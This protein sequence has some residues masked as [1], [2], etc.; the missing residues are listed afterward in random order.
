MLARLVDK[1][2][3]RNRWDEIKRRV[4]QSSFFIYVVGF[5]L[6]KSL[7]LENLSPFAIAFFAVMLT[8]RPQIANILA[9]VVSIGALTVHWQHAIY[10]GGSMVLLMIMYG[11]LEKKNKQDITIIPYQVLGAALISK[12]AIVY[13]ISELSNYTMIMAILESMLALLLTVIYIQ[14]VPIVLG[15]M[16][17]RVLKNEEIIC[18]LI[19]I[20]SIL[21][22]TTNWIWNDVHIDQILGGLAIIVMAY[23]GGTG[24]GAAI[25][26]IIGLIMSL[27]NPLLISQIATLAFAGLLAGL[28]REGKKLFVMV[29]YF[30][31]YITLSIY[32]RPGM[33]LLPVFVEIFT[34]LFLFSIVPKSTINY[35]AGLIPGTSINAWNQIEYKNKVKELVS[36]KVNRYGD[37]LEEL[38]TTFATKKINNNQEAEFQKLIQHV[39]DAS[40]K[41]CNRYNRCWQ[42]D[43]Y[44]SY[45]AFADIFIRFESGESVTPHNLP[46]ELRTQCIDKKRLI[47]ILQQEFTLF[48]KEYYW[49]EQVAECRGLLS[50]QFNGISQVMNQLAVEI[51][52]E[53]L[54]FSKQEVEISRAMEKLGLAIMHTQI[55]NL[56]KGNVE[57]RVTK[58]GCRQRGECTKVLAPMIADIVGENVSVQGKQGCSC[59][60]GECTVLITSAPVYDVE[61]GFVSIGKGGTFVS[62]DSYDGVDL[63]NGKYVLAISDGMG[64]GQRAREESQAAIKL[65]KT[66]LQAG[67]S[68]DTAIKTINAAL[69]LRSN[70]EIFATLDLAFINLFNGDTKFMKV[71]SSPSF[72]KSGNDVDVI[73]GESLPVGILQEIQYSLE[74]KTLKEGNIIVMMSDGILDSIR[75]IN[76][77]EDWLRRVLSQINCDKPQEI[78]DIIVEKVL[79]FNENEVIDDT[80][81]LVAKVNAYEPEWSAIPI[82]NVSKLATN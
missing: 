77:K 10:I 71:G 76:D 54:E 69:M 25:G 52:R 8:R 47:E 21:M 4:L 13:W 55:I 42:D 20:A 41:N 28:L 16:T 12:L 23:A 18:A 73:N 63:G 46:R 64:N 45:H 33:E 14:A 37:M 27:S 78:A 36:G 56:D 68:E 9:I 31:G 5:L 81:V 19:L 53:G 6:G 34:V 62:G 80:T 50:D 67:L 79:R 70:E 24:L 11:I 2:Q 61:Y 32:M 65:L 30:I 38:A 35:V 40:C 66:L 60:D 26:V 17:P 72:I 82:P 15:R 59:N 7:I 43:F 1:I 57:I 3:I 58:N 22:G 49:R 39:A 51:A 48:R 29:G 75:H 44:R 74:R